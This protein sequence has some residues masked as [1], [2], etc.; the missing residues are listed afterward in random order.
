MAS[1]FVAFFLNYLILPFAVAIFVLIIA[2]STLAYA[3]SRTDERLHILEE[4]L[5]EIRLNTKRN[6]IALD[7][8]I[9]G[10]IKVQKSLAAKREQLSPTI[11]LDAF[12]EGIG[13]VM[14]AI[15]KDFFSTHHTSGIDSDVE[16]RMQDLLAK[17]RTKEISLTEAQEL[18]ALLETQKR[19]QEASGDIG[20]AILL[21]LLIIFVLAIIAALVG[22]SREQAQA[23]A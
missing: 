21:G 12:A 17:A 16:R 9:T 10:L 6:G 13:Q 15:S 14:E 1:P 18:Q 11:I 2:F 23:Q 5:K 22:A 3:I 7:A 4:Q 19:R 20:G 8:I